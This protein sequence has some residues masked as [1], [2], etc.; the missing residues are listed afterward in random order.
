MGF[1]SVQFVIKH[2]FQCQCMAT[3]VNRVVR[4]RGREGDVADG[5]KMGTEW[6]VFVTAIKTGHSLRGNTPWAVNIHVLPLMRAP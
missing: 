1:K 6:V 5:S 4:Q 3:Y 2:V